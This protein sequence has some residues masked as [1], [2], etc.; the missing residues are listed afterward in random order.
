MSLHDLIADDAVTVFCNADDFAE[1]VT[2][3]PHRFYGATARATRSITAVVMRE[4]IDAAR[5]TDHPLPVYEVCV[6]NSST[7]GI[8]SAELDTGG[9]ILE[10]PPRDGETAKKFRILR[11]I[12]QDHGMLVLECR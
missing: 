6:A 11:L 10:F 8:S 4:Q 12:T 5:A 1:S 7:T 9:D 2:Y 3:Y